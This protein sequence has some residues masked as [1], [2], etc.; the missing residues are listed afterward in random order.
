MS[1]T[2]HISVLPAYIS[3][4]IEPFTYCSIGK[5]C[6][7]GLRKLWRRPYHIGEC[8]SSSCRMLGEE[9]K[10]K[11]QR[12]NNGKGIEQVVQGKLYQLPLS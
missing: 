6:Q 1:N 12:K 5:S 11:C 8:L 3:A 10:C 9:Q 4:I 2:S 7:E